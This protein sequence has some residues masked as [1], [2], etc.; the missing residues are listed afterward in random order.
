MSHAESESWWFRAKEDIVKDFIAPYLHD[1][2]RS[3][4][5]GLGNGSTIRRLRQIA[6]GCSIS[7]LDLD[8]VAVALCTAQDPCGS[9][10][11]GDI[12]KDD[13][14]DPS[15]A[16]IVIALDILEHLSSDDVV[17]SKVSHCLKPGGYFVVNVPAHPFLFSTHDIYLGHLRRYRPRELRRTIVAE[18]LRIVH[19]TPLFMTTMLLLIIWRRVLQP[20]FGVRTDRSDVDS[21]VP[22]FLDRILYAIAMAEGRIARLSLPFGSSYFIIA[23]KPG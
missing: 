3:V 6:P 20:F 22:S 16:D 23:S 10:K 19:A 5:L 18:G 11:L 15:S 7:G 21:R 14:A 12:E 13:I 4:I 2:S 1:S 8:P 9:F 17:I